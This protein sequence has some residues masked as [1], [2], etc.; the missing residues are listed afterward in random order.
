MAGTEQPEYWQRPRFGKDR[1]GYPVVSVSWYEA[2]AYA[3]VAGRK[4]QTAIGKLQVWSRWLEDWKSA[5]C[6]RIQSSRLPTDSEW[7][8]L[9]G[10]EK[11]GKKDRYPWD[12]P[13]SGRVTDYQ[14]EKRDSD[15][16]ACE[17][18]ESGMG[19]TSPVAMYPLGESKPFRSV[20][21][22]G[23]CVGMDRLVVR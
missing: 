1:H 20:G 13:G 2:T 9:A 23:Q 19:G 22:G 21:S 12:A 11:E 15:P 18:H 14:T 5:F 6:G 3:E 7:L 17:H 16:G 10:G 8:R 4:W